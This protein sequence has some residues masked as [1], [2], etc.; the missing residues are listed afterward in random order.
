M[1]R[2]QGPYRR[3]S[4]HSLRFQRPISNNEKQ[5]E[6]REI[7]WKVGVRDFKRVSGKIERDFVFVKKKGQIVKASVIFQ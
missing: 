2:D 6:K 3:V 4:D 1:H 7:R 5:R